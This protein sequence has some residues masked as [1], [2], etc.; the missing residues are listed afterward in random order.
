MLERKNGW[1]FA[2]TH[3]FEFILK[4]TEVGIQHDRLGSA[5]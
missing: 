2:A 1:F 4:K 5:D 3:F